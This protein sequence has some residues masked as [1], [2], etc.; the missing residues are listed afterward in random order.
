MSAP[1]LSEIWIYPIKSLDGVRVQQ[2][3]FAPGGSLAFDRRW[4]LFAENGAV[5]N[6]K[7]EPRIHQIR[8]TFAA[9]FSTVT[10]SA[11]G[12]LA[13]TFPLADLTGF[14]QWLTGFFGQP[15]EVREESQVG[16]PDDL[17]SPGP[18]LISRAS[19]VEIAS[20]FPELSAEDLQRRLRAN[21]VIDGLH[22]F[23]EDQLFGPSGTR[24]PFRIG[25]VAFAGINPCQRCAVPTR[26]PK[27]GDVWKRFQL[28]FARRREATLPA[29]ADR[30]RFNHFYRAA[31]NTVT[32]L[33]NTGAKIAVGERLELEDA[34]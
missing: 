4:G 5:V 33:T 20:W 31:L 28:E 19:L 1:T 3:G 16:F 23:G 13:A 12:Q 25:D 11:A 29:W 26:D 10:L 14:A 32:E 17:D 18:T 9:D 15:I 2:S 24:V 6:A 34:K 30:S 7:R 22:A 27:T 8:S 21:L